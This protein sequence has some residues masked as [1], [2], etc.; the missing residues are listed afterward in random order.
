LLDRFGLA[1]DVRTPA[2]IADR[3]EV[4]KRRDAFDR[5]PA[6]FCAHWRSEDEAIAARLVKARTR[7]AKVHV[8]DRMLETIA[9]LCMAVGSDGLRG[10]LTVLRAARASAAVDG[11]K[12]VH[13][14]HV[15]TVAAMALR[16][17]LRRN[18]L[19]ESGSEARIARAVFEVL[20][21]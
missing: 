8:D 21:A 2:T 4:V 14:G 19:E 17:R 7:L 12:A 18:P 10:E 6:A 5:D 1:V 16:H 3:V 13:E 20:G 15:K 9:R 11:G